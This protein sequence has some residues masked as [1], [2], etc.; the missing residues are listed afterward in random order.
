MNSQHPIYLITKNIKNSMKS[1][2]LSV[3]V[4]KFINSRDNI[5]VSKT[6]GLS[7]P[8]LES[9]VISWITSCLFIYIS[10]ILLESSCW[11]I[12]IVLIR[13]SA[14]NESIVKS[15]VITSQVI[16]TIWNL[17]TTKVFLEISLITVSVS[18]VI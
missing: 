10:S 13:V 1:N 2:Y 5:R 3:I 16:L 14:G 9:M 4:F 18:I 7:I 8:V 12:R 15:K 17:S 11:V 6:I